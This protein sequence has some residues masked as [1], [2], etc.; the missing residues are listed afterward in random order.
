M[1]IAV[2]KPLFTNPELP[3]PKFAKPDVPPMPE[4]AKPDD[5]LVVLFPKPGA[6]SILRNVI[7]RLS[8]AP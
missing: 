2:P 1:P 3:L 7:V 6:G 8:M 5:G 4:F